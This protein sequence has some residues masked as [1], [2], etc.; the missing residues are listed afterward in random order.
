MKPLTITEII[1]AIDGRVLCPIRPC[2]I[3]GISTDSR[4]VRS[5]DLF[6]AIRGERFDGHDFV[7]TA[8]QQGAL[9][10]VVSLSDRFAGVPQ[11]NRVI[12][13]PSTNAALGQLAA[14]HRRL[15]P[16]TVIAVTGS[17]GKTTTK[18]MITHLLSATRQ[19]RSS[20]KSY[21]NEIGVPLTLLSAGAGDEFL[22]VEVGTNAPGEI[23]ALGRLVR[24]DIAVITS[25]GPAH[26]EKL[27]SIEG[28][29]DEKLSL[30][31]H[32]EPGGAAI[33]NVDRPEVRLRLKPSADLNLIT[34][35]QHAEADL[36]L[37]DVHEEGPLRFRI[38]DRYEVTLRVPGRHNASNALAALAVGRRLG[39]E[40][41]PMIERLASFELPDMRLQMHQYGRLLVINDC[42]NANPASMRAAIEV[43][44]N[45]KAPGRRVAILGDMRELGAASE[46]WH[47]EIGRVIGTS[48]IDLLFSVGDFAEVVCRAAR[49]ARPHQLTTHAA[50]RVHELRDVL[51]D[52]LRPDDT[53][54]LKGSRA[55]QME[56]VLE[57]LPLP[58]TPAA[59]GVLAGG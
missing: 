50:N 41:E 1:S 51:P 5:G 27:L 54:L 19:G 37:T 11:A 29:A 53:I 21:N 42:Y 40:F 31:N 43:L 10:A 20:P 55:M 7:E 39:L 36:R 38:N 32:M 3:S 33:V 48:R 52:L 18:A 13:V 4:Q 2:S 23:T 15:L 28:V 14:Y 45:L 46:Q 56:K 58:A 8:L 9:F 12:V 35:G 49:T 6:V 47:H 25:V 26:L 30:L 17:N 22:V 16:A 34:F 44:D 57:M 24:P 59:A